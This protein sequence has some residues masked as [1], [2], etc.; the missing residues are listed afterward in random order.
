MLAATCIGRFAVHQNFDLC[1]D[2][3]LN[4][5]E[6]RILDQHH[7]VAAVPAEWRDYQN[8]MK[9]PYENY[10]AEKGYWASGFL[11]GFAGLD[12]LFGKF[13]LAWALSPTLA[14]LSILLLASVARRTFP[15]HPMLG[16]NPAVL[17]LA[18]SPQFL[19]MA[20]TQFAWTAHLCGSLL[21]VWLFSHPNRVL[22]LLTPILGAL[23]IGLH[24]PHVH[25]LVAAPFVLRL[26]YDRRWKDFAWFVFWYL[27]GAWAWYQVFALLRPTAFATGGD[28][29]N[30][31]PASAFSMI[32][33][34][35]S[36][37]F[38]T[39][40]AITL[41]AWATPALIPFLG[42]FLFTWKKQPPLVRDGFLAVCLTFL[43]YLFF[44]HPQ[45][46]GWG[47]RYL[48]SVY[49]LLALAAAGG[50]VTLCREGWNSQVSKALLAGA[51]F[52]L[53][54]QIPWRIHE[55]RTMV[56]PLALTWDYISKQPSDF[57]IIKTSDFWYSWDLIRNDP[58]LRQKPLVFNGDK[59]TPGQWKDL[60]RKGTVT[61]IGVD[62]VRGFGVI[63]SDPGKSPMP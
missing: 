29:N 32:P 58:W 45:G 55:I 47:F 26:M 10:N 12:Y 42:M 40:H 50:A 49:G 37:I 17:L 28:L 61:V 1:I 46:H 53:L 3:Y 43:F 21:W 38:A 52:S 6:V 44:P 56:R 23:L 36:L 16:A 7:L 39:F 60:N 24:Q 51:V 13:D 19:A 22:F 4:G 57:V 48:H 31:L 62:Q 5:F 9:V 11:P 27:I 54:V 35:L 59:L 15:D 63:L 8:A 34:L 33:V 25:P 41:F 20:M 2:E 30:F 18:L 14:A